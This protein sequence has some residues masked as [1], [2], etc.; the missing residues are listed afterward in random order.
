MDFFR[1]SAQIT[2]QVATIS[3]RIMV[4]SFAWLEARLANDPW[5]GNINGKLM[6]LNTTIPINKPR[7]PP[8]S[9]QH[10]MQNSNSTAK[11]SS[12]IA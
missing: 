11:S 8:K 5:G 10:P 4:G 6:R 2:S 1:A 12:G 9:F 7:D 3:T